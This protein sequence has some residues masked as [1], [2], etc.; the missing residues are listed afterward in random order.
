VTR[1]RTFALM[2][3]AL[4]LVFVL[5]SI[6]TLANTRNQL[7]DD[8]DQGLADDLAIS[9]QLYNSYGIDEI[10]QLDAFE[11]LDVVNSPL[12]TVLVD[13]PVGQVLIDAPAG[14][15]GDPLARP[16]L[17][18]DRIVE[19]AGE[20][21]TVDGTHDGPQYRVTVGQLDDGRYLALAVP[22]NEVRHTIRGLS[23]T[24]A[25]TLVAMVTV[26]S[27]II[28]F[29]QRASFRPFY[30]I[31]DTAE[32]IADGNMD[33]RAVQTSSDPEI[34]GLTTSLN[35]M[36]D[37]LQHSFEQRERAEDRVKQF[38]ADASHEL[39]TPL[40][41]IAGYS[42]SYLLGAAN[43]P[44]AVRKQ[45][46]RI[47]SEAHRMGR[48]VN[49]LLTL[50]RLDQGHAFEAQPVDLISLVSDAVSDARVTDPSHQL[51][52]TKGNAGSIYV[53]GDGDALQ[54]VVA[55]LIAN[56]RVHAPTARVEITIDTF[57]ETHATIAISDDGPGMTSEVADNV[58]DRF[59]RAGPSP[60]SDARGT[61]LGL[62]IVAAIVE[63][64]GGTVHLDTAPR[65]GSTFT[66]TLPTVSRPPRARLVRRR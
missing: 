4:V 42:E 12:A 19:G 48:L 51:Q 41:T 50:A 53:A 43:D 13:A 8:I 7:I 16:D 62:S 20:T 6:A 11:N 29:L 14:P 47:N 46:T 66:I 26:L 56:T 60:S 38:A 59:Y 25:A 39:R 40:T 49:D 54:Q 36:L 9:M 21:F 58:F 28:F 65:A 5:G 2:V 57:D 15:V 31:V 37:R 24:L 10:G 22:L 45:M 64:H 63:T 23:R 32:S 35:T 27:V 44:D 52:L 17:S 3:L 55:N 33:R 18:T 61:G 1:R 34:R 30:E